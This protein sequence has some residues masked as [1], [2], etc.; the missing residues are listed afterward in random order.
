MTNHLRENMQI[1]EQKSFLGYE[2]LT[3]LFLLLDSDNAKNKVLEIT[4]NL[5]FKIDVSMVLGSRVTTCLFDNKEQKTSVACP[6]LESSYEV[7]A[8]LKNGHLIESLALI[9]SFD[10]LK[11]SL[12]LHAQD[13]ALTQVKIKNNFD[14]ESLTEQEDLSEAEK[15]SEEI[16]LRIST[17]SDA[18]KIVDAFNEYFLR[19]RLDHEAYFSQLKNM[20]EQVENRLAHHFKKDLNFAAV[21]MQI[22][23]RNLPG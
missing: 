8:S 1:R 21:Q 18:E 12:M 23:E 20:R 17:L 14:N 22:R 4:Q 9:I 16:F 2:F 6:I 3:W 7:F 19:L 15:I 10:E 11:I 5:L 13:F